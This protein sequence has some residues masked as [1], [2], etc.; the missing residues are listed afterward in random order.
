MVDRMESWRLQPLL[1]RI[2]PLPLRNIV[3]ERVFRRNE[4]RQGF[5]LTQVFWGRKYSEDEE[6]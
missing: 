5:K 2:A 3:P 6:P 1:S 4:A